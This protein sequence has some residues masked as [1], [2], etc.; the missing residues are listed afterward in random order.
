MKP[1]GGDVNEF[2]AAVTPAVRRR[3]AETMVRL[4]SEVSGREPVLW[5]TIVGFGSYHYRYPTGTEGDAPLLGFAP[6]RQATTVY[7][8]DPRDDGGPDLTGLGPHTT[9]ASC[10][11]LKDLADIDLDVLRRAVKRSLERLTS[12][13]IEYAEITV[14]G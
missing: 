4:L 5:G 3:D 12:G 10:L 11:Y 13:E 1:T 8:L 14:T 9:G 7:L 2:L 6:R